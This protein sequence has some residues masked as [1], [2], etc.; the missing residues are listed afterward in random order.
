MT[1]KTWI[2]GALIVVCALMVSSAVMAQGDGGAP[3]IVRV[4]PN[5]D[6]PINR[7][8]RFFFSEPM[9]R[10]SVEAAFDV[11]PDVS[12]KFSWACTDPETDTGCTIMTFRPND[13]YERQSD[14][15][16]TIGTGA[17]SESGGALAE[18]FTLKLST[19]LFATNPGYMAMGYITALVILA[20][21]VGWIVMRYRGQQREAA[22]IEQLDAESKTDAVHAAVGAMESDARLD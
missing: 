16:F 14:Y 6:L 22:R 8:V 3:E 5:D 18:P 13:H 9:N 17:Q 4:Q 21:M 20:G 15:T 19:G 11:E 10:E 1:T 12:G 7:P 2:L